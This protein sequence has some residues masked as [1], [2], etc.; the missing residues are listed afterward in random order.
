MKYKNLNKSEYKII[1]ISYDRNISAALFSDSKKYVNV[2]RRDSYVLTHIS[3]S[4]I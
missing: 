2:E 3:K 4:W 1:Y